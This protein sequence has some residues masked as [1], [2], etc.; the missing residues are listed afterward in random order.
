MFPRSPRIGQ[1][2][3]LML[4]NKANS[5][6]HVIHVFQENLKGFLGLLIPAKQVGLLGRQTP[7]PADAKRFAQRISLAC[8]QETKQSSRFVVCIQFH[9]G[10]VIVLAGDLILG[11]ELLQV[12]M[13]PK[14][15]TSAQSLHH[16]IHPKAWAAAVRYSQ[17]RSLEGVNAEQAFQMLQDKPRESLTILQCLFCSL[18][19][20]GGVRLLELCMQEPEN[21]W[22]TDVHQQR[23]GIERC[24]IS[25][26]QQS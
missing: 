22:A 3:A 5:E 23:C 16:L 10:H 19:R 6:L 9:H 14:R 24:S 18:L 15:W 8:L 12:L 17:R 2:K 21:I 13:L 26:S 4:R 25:G 7:L 11:E 20:I 1:R